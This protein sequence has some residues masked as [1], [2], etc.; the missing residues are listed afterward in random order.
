VASCLP[1]KDDPEF[2]LCNVG[3]MREGTISDFIE[4]YDV[5]KCIELRDSKCC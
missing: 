4:N 5:L 2:T 3:E 1:F